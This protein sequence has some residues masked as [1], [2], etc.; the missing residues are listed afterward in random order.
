MPRN[1]TVTTRRIVDAT[2]GDTSLGTVSIRR[3]NVAAIDEVT[4]NFLDTCLI[5]R[6][7]HGKEVAYSA[8][9]TISGDLYINHFGDKPTEYHV[10]GV[11]FDGWK[12][13]EETRTDPLTNLYAFYRDY[14]L[15]AAADVGTMVTITTYNMLYDGGY[16]NYSGLLTKMSADVSADSTG[17]RQYQF[18]LSFLSLD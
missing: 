11:A 8:E 16:K 13:A 17:V 2:P 3:N 4:R 14:R 10:E 18:S 9:P 6:I 12:C 5:T 15:T 7:R 1:G